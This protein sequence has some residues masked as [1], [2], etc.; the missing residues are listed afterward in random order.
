MSDLRTRAAG[1]GGDRPD[2]ANLP[3][4][5]DQ[6]ADQ[7]T[8]AA[9]KGTEARQIIRD[10]RTCLQTIPNLDRCAPHSVLGAVM[11]GT[12]LGLRPGVLGQ[13]WPLPFWDGRAGGFK[14]QFILGYQGM[15]DLAYRH[16][17][18]RSLSMETVFE[19]DEYEVLLGT[20][21]GIH[22]KPGKAGERGDAVAFYATLETANG[23]VLFH[24]MDV[25]DIRAHR[26]AFAPRNKAKKIVG[27]WGSP[28]DSAEWRGMAKKTCVRQLWKV[29]PRATEYY[30]GISTAFEVDGMVRV[31]TSADAAP[32][33]VS[34]FEAAGEL[35]GSADPVPEGVDAATGEVGD[36]YD[37]TLEPGFGKAAE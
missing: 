27:P 37:P 31:N 29:A 10:V 25:E 24:A 19:G 34:S 3:V 20:Q 9:P 26:D 8:A 15:I 30:P 13:Y 2:I 17:M 18:V 23:G 21:R 12:Q 32:L 11:T 33:E 22:H 4:L 35:E 36:E 14:A 16:P 6:M 5:L 28:E 1:G 7:F